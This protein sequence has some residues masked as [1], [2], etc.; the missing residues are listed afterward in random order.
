M[1]RRFWEQRNNLK[2]IREKVEKILIDFG[3]EAKIITGTA[4]KAIRSTAPNALSVMMPKLMPPPPATSKYIRG[5]KMDFP[6]LKK[7]QDRA[8][9]IAYLHESTA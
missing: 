8:D 2:V 3:K 9:L 1:E 4:P 7:A 5:T 6:G